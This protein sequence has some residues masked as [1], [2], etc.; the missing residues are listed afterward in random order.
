MVFGRVGLVDHGK[1]TFSKLALFLTQTSQKDAQVVK[2]EHRCAKNKQSSTGE[3][4]GE[5]QEGRAGAGGPEGQDWGVCATGPGLED[6]LQAPWSC[7][8]RSKC[9]LGNVCS[10][11]PLDKYLY[12]HLPSGALTWLLTSSP[13]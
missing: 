2:E 13:A 12:I 5:V 6:K 4:T 3:G 8:V 7:C 9:S 11:L 1:G 10:P